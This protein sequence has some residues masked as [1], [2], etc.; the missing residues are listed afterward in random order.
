[1]AVTFDNTTF[2]AAQATTGALVLNSFTGTSLLSGATPVTINGTIDQPN[3][4]VSVNLNIANVAYTGASGTYLGF[5][6]AQNG[7]YVYY[8]GVSGAGLLTP[9]TIG[10]TGAAALPDLSVL[11]PIN[12]ANVTAP[13]GPNTPPC[14]VTGTRI[15]TARGEVA[16]EHLAVGDR[17]VTA[18]GAERPVRWI[19]HR[20]VDCARHPEPRAVWPVRVRAGAFG[21]GLPARDLWLSPDHAVCVSVLDEVLIPVKHLMNDATVAQVPVDEVGYW[22][23]ELDGH[24]ILLAEGL[25]SESFLDTGVRAAFANGAEHA[26]L[27]PDFA[28]RAHGDFCRPLIQEGAIV[29]AVRARLAARAAALGWTITADPDLRAVADGV[30]IR[31]VMEGATARFAL[32]AGTRAV[33]LVSRTFAPAGLDPATGDSRR[34]GVPL[35]GLSIEGEVARSLAADDPR[36]SA[37]FSFAQGGAGDTWRWTD[38]DAQLPAD[39]WEGVA[40]AFTLRVALVPAQAWAG[41]GVYAVP[42]AERGE[43]LAAAA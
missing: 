25:P 36:L 23:V 31:P 29:R 37:G 3:S 13:V 27:H 2:G 34:L 21:E 32:P 40:G 7:D 20:R 9:V 10:V 42:R 38:G 39:L 11:T 22:H 33:R 28:P 18:S 30:V 8:F 14:F 35:R 41:D 1:M 6:P 15:R 19:G 16:V 4:P 26:V 43:D 17:V 24:E 5:S 12:T